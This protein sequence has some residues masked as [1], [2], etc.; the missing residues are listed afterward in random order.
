[1]NAFLRQMYEVVTSILTDP[2]RRRYAVP[3]TVQEEVDY[4]QA[5]RDLMLNRVNL[6]ILDI[7]NEHISPIWKNSRT[8]AVL[9]VGNHIAAQ[10]SQFLLNLGINAIVNC[11]RPGLNGK[12]E[13]PNYHESSP[14]NFRYYNF[15]VRSSSDVVLYLCRS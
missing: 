5:G 6:G 10:D 13:L 12:G 9:Y 1:M 8:G 14:Y 2:S 15:P 3:P 4:E 11:T 7:G